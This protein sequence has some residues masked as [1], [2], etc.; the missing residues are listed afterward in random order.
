MMKYRI[1]KRHNDNYKYYAQK[2]IFGIWID[3]KYFDLISV[4]SYDSY[5]DSFEVVRGWIDTKI[6][7]Q[8]YPKEEVVEIYEG[9]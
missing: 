5:D 9:P 8:K 1:V 7:P 3:C 2:C 4:H 6:N